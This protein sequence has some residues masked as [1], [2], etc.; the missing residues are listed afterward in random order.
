M[1]DF[2]IYYTARTVCPTDH[3]WCLLLKGKNMS[4]LE[5]LSFGKYL[6]GAVNIWSSTFI[7]TAKRYLTIIGS[8]NYATNSHH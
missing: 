3:F 6:N 8:M 4:K 7:L 2:I 1:Y 5:I